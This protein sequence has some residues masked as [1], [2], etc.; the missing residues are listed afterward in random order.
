MNFILK[1]KEE[2]DVSFYS[3]IIVE[4]AKERVIKKASKNIS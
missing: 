2:I 3:N 1:E 4:C